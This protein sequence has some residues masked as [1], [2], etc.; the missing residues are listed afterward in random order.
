KPEEPLVSQLEKTN[1]GT[2]F[3][4]AAPT[5]ADLTKFQPDVAN[6][7][8]PSIGLLSGT[9]LGEANF[10]VIYNLTG[11]E[12]KSVSMENQFDALLYLGQ[13]HAECFAARSSYHV[14]R[15][16][17]PSCSPANRDSGLVVNC[18]SHSWA[19]CGFVSG[20]QKARMHKVGSRIVITLTLVAVT[21]TASSQPV[22]RS[23]G[24]DPPRIQR[25]V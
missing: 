11:A 15:G 5:E 6:W 14:A 2:V 3:S 25:A 4:I 19:Q 8:A 13:L 18:R 21:W 22:N 16:N 7:H 12:F 20:A 9:A 1:P 24:S 23:I 10:G 17:C